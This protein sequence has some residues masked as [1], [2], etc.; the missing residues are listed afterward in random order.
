[1]LQSAALGLT[2]R[3]FLEQIGGVGGT[4]LMLTGMDALGFGIQS[5]APAP[6]KL[7]S[8]RGK[9][10]VI[11]GAGMAGL[12]SAYELSN[13]G[14]QVTLLEAR[15]RPGG[16]SYTARRGTKLTEL[17]GQAQVCQFDEG[18]YINCGPWRIPYFHRGYLHYARK[19]QVPVELFNNDNDHS[20]IYFD[21]GAGPL[22]GKAVRK[23]RIAADVR[24]YAAEILAKQ[25]N[26]GA[27]DQQFTP[28]DKEL[29]IDYLRSE[30]HL[31]G[32]DLRYVAPCST[33]KAGGR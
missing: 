29:F 20:Y 27:L 9:R 6:P 8:G 11:L 2:R 17:G 16:R 26:Q 5:A 4:A 1:M 32:A 33:R 19:M 10:V 22:A 15:D 14:Y 28:G 7:G 21:N 13:A 30:G 24:G 3:M 31:E 18:H 23:Q 12:T 25:V